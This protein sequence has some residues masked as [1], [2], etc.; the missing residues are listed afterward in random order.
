VHRLPTDFSKPITVDFPITCSG[1]FMFFIEHESTSPTR[2]SQRVRSDPGYLN[3]DPILQVPARTSIIDPETHAI[4]PVGKGGKVLDKSVPLPLDGLAIQ[5]VIAKW[6]G[7]IDEWAP[8]L[9]LTRDRGY[10]MIHFTPLQKRGASDSP[11]SIFDQLEF[12]DD[13]FSKEQ[14]KGSQEARAKVVQDGLRR[15][16][17]EWGILS[18]T[19]VVWNHTAHNSVWLESHPESGKAPLPDT[20]GSEVALTGEGN[21]GYNAENSPHLF[22]ALELDTALLDLSASL[23]THGL[24]TAISSDSDISL[25]I[26]HLRDSVLP[27]LRLWECYV[28]D[29]ARAKGD[30]GEAWSSGEKAA[31]DQANGDSGDALKALSRK[32]LAAELARRCLPANWNQLGHRFH[33]TLDTA[34]AIRFIEELTGQKPGEDTVGTAASVLAD[35]LDEVNLSMYEL[36]DDDVKAILENTRNRIRYT[37]L[38][39]HGP[40]LGKITA[41]YVCP[42]FDPLPD[43]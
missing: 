17:D 20:S 5:T 37:R 9:D 14:A 4:L 26:E 29:V 3:V 33:A 39:A 8:H 13:L 21:A 23:S 7:S 27:S 30:F 34:A 2:E 25:V 40:L 22:P 42:S 31:T 32:E 43:C 16:R 41:R 24:P 15:I 36:Y 6:M 35:L 12:A 38:D 19:D 1:A 18:L 28:V 11:Y 10:N